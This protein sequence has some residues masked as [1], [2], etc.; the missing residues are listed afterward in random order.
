MA[1]CREILPEVAYCDGVV[2]AAENADGLIIL[3]E[4]NQFRKLDF[5]HLRRVMRQPLVVDLRNLYDPVET[6]RAGFRYVSVGR[7]TA[8]PGG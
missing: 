5:E 8:E 1:A 4:W 2:E 7:A 6:A 3:T